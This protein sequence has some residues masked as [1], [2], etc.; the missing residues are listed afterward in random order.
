MY[1]PLTSHVSNVLKLRMFGMLNGNLI[2]HYSEKKT[3]NMIQHPF[4]CSFLLS[5]KAAICSLMLCEYLKYQVFYCA[6][7]FYLN[8][9]DNIIPII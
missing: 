9:F 1:I 5:D 3:Q 7:P 6:N 8:I 2:V 4:T